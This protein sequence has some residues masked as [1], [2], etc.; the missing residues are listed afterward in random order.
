MTETRGGFCCVRKN[1]IKSIAAR[2]GLWYGAVEAVKIVRR[3]L[4]AIIELLRERPLQAESVR[5]E[6]TGQADGALQ[7]RLADAWAVEHYRVDREGLVTDPRPAIAEAFAP[8]APSGAEPGLEA[9][10]TG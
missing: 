2:C 4:D 7:L 1:A 10:S 9:A 3:Q 6:V 5:L 8:P